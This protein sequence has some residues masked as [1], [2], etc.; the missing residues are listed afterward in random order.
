MKFDLTQKIVLVPFKIDFYLTVPSI[1]IFYI[2]VDFYLMNYG[3][4]LI[5]IFSKSYPIL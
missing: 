1:S 3:V 2:E 4:K 5:S